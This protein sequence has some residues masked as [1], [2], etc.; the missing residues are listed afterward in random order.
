MQSGAY[1]QGGQ[2]VTVP[3]P[4]DQIPLFVA[5]GSVIPQG[6]VMRHVDQLPDDL[7]VLHLFP[8]Q[9]TGE[10]VSRLIEDDGISLAYQQGAYTELLFRLRSTPKELHL[11]IA[12]E[13]FG[14]ELPY[15]ELSILLPKDE[16]RPL[17]ISCPSSLSVK[18]LY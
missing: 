9:N 8:H 10:R 4:L 13:H 14:Y 3:A 12:F 16:L 11:D 1:H 7:R 17:Q 2:T 18:L 15:K 6:K 5:A